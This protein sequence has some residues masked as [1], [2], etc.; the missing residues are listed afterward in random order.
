VDNITKEVK[1]NNPRRAK[2]G[3][4]FSYTTDQKW[5]VALLELVYDMNAR[6]LVNDM[7]APDYLF[8]KILSW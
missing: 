3:H 2:D 1:D 4:S 6:L 5:T 7:N 8:C